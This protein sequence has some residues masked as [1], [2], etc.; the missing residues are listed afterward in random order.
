MTYRKV[1]DALEAFAEGRGSQWDWD[2]Y[3]SATF[4]ADPYLKHVQERMTDLSDE[5]P[6][7]R[8]QGYCNPEGLQIIRDYVTELRNKAAEGKP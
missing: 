3:T 2:D 6:A 7:E 8:G 5:F 4:F 1:A